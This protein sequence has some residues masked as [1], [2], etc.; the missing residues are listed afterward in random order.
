MKYHICT[1]LIL[2][3][4]R[5]GGKSTDDD[6]DQVSPQQMSEFAEEM[7]AALVVNP[8]DVLLAHPVASRLLPAHFVVFDR[9][10]RELLVCIRG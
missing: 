5:S 10:H 7:A 8:A 6:A 1:N 9:E 4:N 2:Q 3:H